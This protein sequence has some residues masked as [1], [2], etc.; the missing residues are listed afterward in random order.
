MS[1]DYSHR[2]AVRL[3]GEDR[4]F[5]I[6][7]PTTGRKGPLEELASARRAAQAAANEASD[8]WSRRRT[9][10]AYAVYRATQDR[11]DAVQDRLAACA[12]GIA[13]QSHA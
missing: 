3:R 11:A 5:E 2:A 13:S 12:R 10:D 8:D 9:S 7:R 6:I 1:E 4:T